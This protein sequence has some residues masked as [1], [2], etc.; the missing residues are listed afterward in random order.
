MIC[1]YC[2][3][4][5]DYGSDFCGKCG[6]P[7]KNREQSNS[8]AP[9]WS[10]GSAGG[11]GAI[12]VIGVGLILAGVLTLIIGLIRIIN[13][14]QYASNFKPTYGSWDYWGDKAFY[15]HLLD[16]GWFG[17]ILVVAFFFWAICCGAQIRKG[18]LK[19]MGVYVKGGAFIAVILLMDIIWTAIKL[20]EYQKN[21]DYVSVTKLVI[22]LVV[23]LFVGIILYR[24]LVNSDAS[25]QYFKRG[26]NYMAPSTTGY[27][28]TISSGNGTEG[29][30]ML[31]R[32]VESKR[33]E[34]QDM[35]Y[36][37]MGQ[38]W[39]CAN[40]GTKT[41]GTYQKCSRCGLARNSSI[42]LE[43]IKKKQ[44]EAEA[45]QEQEARDN[46]LRCFQ[47]LWKLGLITGDELEES[48]DRFAGGGI[49]N[50]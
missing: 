44:S 10:S 45:K 48:R 27:G 34:E 2:G 30:S 17:I 43:G 33:Q 36:E 5:N 9:S 35:I 1:P 32:A 15:R 21:L 16:Y 39:T 11:Y 4:D 46:M 47:E 38:Y 28:G 42:A 14:F 8:L 41:L 25:R 23:C 6:M 26:D 49:G 20:G 22:W 29:L 7:Q 3:A 19:F 12:P 13:Y 31:E 18:S 50:V 37:Q 24:Y 40:C